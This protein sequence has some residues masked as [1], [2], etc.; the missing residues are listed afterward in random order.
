MGSSV[1]CAVRRRTRRYVLDT[2]TIVEVPVRWTGYE[3]RVELPEWSLLPFAR[4]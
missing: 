1:C 2:L 4:G 3:I